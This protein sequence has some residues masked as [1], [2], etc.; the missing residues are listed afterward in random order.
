[1][2]VSK[3]PSGPW[4]A[5]LKSGRQYV[6]GKTFDSRREVLGL[7]L[8]RAGADDRSEPGHWYPSPEGRST[9]GRAAS[10]QR[11][12]AGGTVER[13][14]RTKPAPGGP[15]SCRGVDGVALVRAWRDAC[16]GFRA[17]ADAAA[18]RA[19]SRAGGRGRQGDEER[20]G[21]RVPLAD[22]VLPLVQEMAKGRD[23]EELLF[24][25][26]TGHRLHASAVKRT[27]AWSSVSAGRRIH[28]LRHTAA[29]LWLARGVDPARVQA[30]VACHEHG[31]AVGGFLPALWDHLFCQSW[32]TRRV[33][34]R[35]SGPAR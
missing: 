22:R 6:A 27:I 33:C 12:T 29:C 24:V 20:H 31:T 34:R 7:R 21:R 13:G 11:R 9:G 23:G 18:R 30:C 10:I 8:G 1:M 26:E 17:G 16:P 5:R 14:R 32:T 15:P 25:T 3:L 19:A 35:G 28:D 2:S 4:H